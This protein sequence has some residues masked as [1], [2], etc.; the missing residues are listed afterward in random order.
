MA[1]VR[2]TGLGSLQ[3]KFRE[4]DRRTRS[5]MV[6]ALFQQGTNIMD[7]S[8]QRV[9][10]D[11]GALKKSAYVEKPKLR[12]ANMALG[13]GKIYAAYQHEETSLRHPKGGTAKYLSRAINKI[14]LRYVKDLAAKTRTNLRKKRGIQAVKAKYPT[15]AKDEKEAIDI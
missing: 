1:I 2:V 15:K 3:K 4:A 5:A 12:D 10:V 8:Q 13:Y 7:D 14:R 9:P 6:A 11:T